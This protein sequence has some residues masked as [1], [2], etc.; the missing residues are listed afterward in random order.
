MR[1]CANDEWLST[2]D[3]AICW[4]HDR[5]SP[6][7]PEST[8]RHHNPRWARVW[9][10]KAKNWASS[11]VSPSGVQDLA[12]EGAARGGAGAGCG[13]AATGWGLVGGGGGGVVTGAAVGGGVVG[14]AVVVVAGAEVDDAMAP[15]VVDI[16]SWIDPDPCWVVEVA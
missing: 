5:A 10:S 12:A 4:L 9:L 15:V 1:F 7:N 16:E 3:A 2:L 14:G 8:V 6:V 13:A 11:G